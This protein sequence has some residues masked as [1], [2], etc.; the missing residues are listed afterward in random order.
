[1]IPHDPLQQLYDLDRT[2]PQFHEQLSGL[3]RGREYQD[4]FPNLRSE[5]LSWLVEYLDSVS[6]PNH[7]CPPC[8]QDWYGIGS[9]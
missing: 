2:S 3:L 6:F 8:A 5:D 9:G 4:V 7:L 1:M